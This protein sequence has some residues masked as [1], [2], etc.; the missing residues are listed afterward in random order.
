[1]SGAG[2]IVGVETARKVRCGGRLGGFLGGPGARVAGG[3]EPGAAGL[4]WAFT[5]QTLK[6]VKTLKLG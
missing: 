6:L 5:P 4:G 3:P 1:M 2:A